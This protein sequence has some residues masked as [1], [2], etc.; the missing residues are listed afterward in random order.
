MQRQTLSR[1]EC[2]RHPPPATAPFSPISSGS[3]VATLSHTETSE[4]PGDRLTRDQTASGA[5]KGA[6]G[7]K[8]SFLRPVDGTFV[9]GRE[10]GFGV[11]CGDPVKRQRSLLID[12][13]SPSLAPRNRNHLHLRSRFVLQTIDS[14]SRD[15]QSLHGRS[16]ERRNHEKGRAKQPHD[17]VLSFRSQTLIDTYCLPR[18]RH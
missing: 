16:S 10:S 17:N 15:K 9:Q 3:R 6:P 8:D 12:W 7:D 18:V 13:R 4:C 2:R 11:G 1:Q 5:R 14:C